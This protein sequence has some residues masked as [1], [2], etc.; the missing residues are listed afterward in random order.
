MTINNPDKRRQYYR[1]RYRTN[2]QLA[3]DYAALK[4]AEDV[5][6]IAASRTNPVER[7]R[8]V[9]DYLKEYCKFRRSMVK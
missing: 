4:C 1:N 8:A 7:Q 5:L 3:I 9:A 2:A 6:A